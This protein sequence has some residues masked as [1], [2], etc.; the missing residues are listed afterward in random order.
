M[1]SQKR[2]VERDGRNNAQT[3]LRRSL[4]LLKLVLPFCERERREDA[5]DRTPLGN[6]Q[7]GLG[8]TRDASYDDD[9]EN[10]S[11]GKEEPV[12]DCGRGKHGKRLCVRLPVRAAAV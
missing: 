7:S 4:V 8:Q 5:R 6:A 12:R 9:R 10:E 2:G 3:E 1:S 11:G